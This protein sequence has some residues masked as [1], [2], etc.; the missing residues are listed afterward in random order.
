MDGLSPLVVATQ[1]RISSRSYPTFFV[2]LEMLSFLK[3]SVL[4]SLAVLVAG[5]NTY[6]DNDVDNSKS[7]TLHH[8]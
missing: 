5:D 3:L 2:L 8:G 1:L 6:T 7:E 4:A